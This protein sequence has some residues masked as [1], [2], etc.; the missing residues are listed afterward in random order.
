MSSFWTTEK[1]SR[2]DD[3]LTSRT[4]RVSS[5][6]IS[7]DAVMRSVAQETAPLLRL[8]DVEAYYGP[9]QALFGVGLEVW[10]GEIVCLL[11]GNASGKSTTMRAIIGTL[12]IT[13]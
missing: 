7:G 1:I 2:K 9:V 11:G 6:P 5:K 12:S 4:I 8:S 13:G 3:R 10:P